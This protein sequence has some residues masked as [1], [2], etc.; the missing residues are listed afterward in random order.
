[1]KG[2]RPLTDAEIG[3]VSEAFDGIY[4]I[5]NRSL[6]WLGIS[7]GGRISE[8]LALLV[9]DV[10][11]NGKAVGDVLFDRSIVKGGEISRAVP[12][13]ADGR[14]TVEKLIDWHTE[15][16]GAVDASRLLFP[17]RKRNGEG[18]MQRQSAHEILKKAFEKSGVNGK[19]A[20]HSLRKTYAQRL[21]NKSGDI[22][23]VK[24]MLG[25][26]SV[27][28]TEAY[29]GVN[30]E[31]VRAASEAICLLSEN[32][33]TPSNHLHTATDEALLFELARRGHKVTLE[34]GKRKKR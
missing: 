29:L 32:G 13:N 7:T 14:D 21:Y 3:L 4:E 19:L 16:Y 27:T 20:T 28:S 9:G 24:E 18:L 31:K 22:Y 23:V 2:T 33:S 6:F 30:Y 34:T 5:R 17:S 26:Q 1:M 25:H 10:Y 15:K 8:L 11:Q 12:L